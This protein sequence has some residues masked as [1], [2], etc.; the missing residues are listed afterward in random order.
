[1]TVGI[2]AFVCSLATGLSTILHDVVPMFR[3]YAR[4]GVVVQLMTALLAAVGAQR[5]WESGVAHARIACVVLIALG[6][7]EY[8][9]WPP[10]MSR[11]VLPTQAHRWVAAQPNRLRVLDCTPPAAESGDVRWLT[12][13][14]ISNA[15]EPFAD[16][17]EPNFPEKLAVAGYTHLI[18]RAG[19]GE[20]RS[21]TSR[22]VPPGL[23]QAAHFADSDLY[24]V[25]ALA[26]AV[27]T[28]S[29][30]GFHP[31]EHDATWT[32]RWMEGEASW[33][34]SNRRG[35]AVTANLD[36]EMMT[37][38]RPLELTVLLD[39]V[40][41][42]ALMIDESRSLRRIAS[43]RLTPGDHALTFRPVRPPAVHARFTGEEQRP[44]SFRIGTWRWTIEAIKP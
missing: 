18:V 39:G 4:F 21:F 26:P 41:T 20:L 35:H 15:V 40:E 2:A 27:H 34:I 17:G 5:L 10:S 33:T 43:L 19:T 44:L 31:R 38:G 16:C 28:V 22:R 12:Q 1:V 24:A 23:Q 13:Y 25:A 32:W 36:V 9:V 6:V 42:H 14:R 8:A 29:M 37:F 30:T 7:A 3:A 11:D